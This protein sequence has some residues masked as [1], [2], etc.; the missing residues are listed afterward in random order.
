MTSSSGNPSDAPLPPIRENDSL[1]ESLKAF[2]TEGQPHLEDVFLELHRYRH[3]M[4]REVELILF[5]ILGRYLHTM[6]DNVLNH[7]L[8]PMAASQAALHSVFGDPHVARYIEAILQQG[9][10]GVVKRSL[11]GA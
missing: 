7:D 9:V 11:E 4:P 2:F 1:R 3:M 8:D 5:H 6:A 10:A